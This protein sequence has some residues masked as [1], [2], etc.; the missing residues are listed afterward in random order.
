V[1]AL[2]VS[3]EYMNSGMERDAENT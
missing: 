1:Q 2:T 3:V